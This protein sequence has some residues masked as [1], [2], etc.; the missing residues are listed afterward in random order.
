M[1]KEVYKSKYAR[2][3]YDSGTEIFVIK[4][5]SETEDMD[6]D[7]WKEL[8]IQLE[9]DC[10][11]YKPKYLLSD[12]QDRKYSYAPDMQAWTLGV[13]LPTWTKNGLIKYVQVLSQELIGQLSSEQ[14]IELANRQLSSIFK[15]I[16]FGD[17]E[18]A[19]KWLKE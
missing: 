4:Y 10:D 2:F 18:S 9:K 13:L 14:I 12:N 8:I 19:I 3:T 15:N 11:K 1:E 16:F 17:Y 5:F 7:E 6:D